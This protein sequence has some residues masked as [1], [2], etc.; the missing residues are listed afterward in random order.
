MEEVRPVQIRP[1]ETTT[2]ERAEARGASKRAGVEGAHRG[3]ESACGVAG[4][5]ERGVGSARCEEM[6]C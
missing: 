2:E 4:D 5:A 3:G 1:I 6:V